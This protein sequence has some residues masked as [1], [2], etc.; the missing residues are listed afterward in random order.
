MHG[1]VDGDS[2]LSDTETVKTGVTRTEDEPR[3]AL[4]Y[5]LP[6]CPDVAIA[7]LLRKREED[8]K[9]ERRKEPDEESEDL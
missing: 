1:P 3:P 4:L 8:A 5:V 2:V 7:T 6:G 9:N